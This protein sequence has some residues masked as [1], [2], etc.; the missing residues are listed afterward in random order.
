MENTL[1]VKYQ[2]KAL[3]IVVW[4]YSLSVVSAVGFVAF[5]RFIGI[6]TSNEIKW[7]SLLVFAVVIV[8]ELIALA[9]LYKQTS[10]PEKWK[11]YFKILNFLL[12]GICYVNYIFLNVLVPSREIW[13]IVFY[14]I[15]LAALFLDIKM[16]CSSIVLSVICNVILLKIDV[17]FMPDKQFVFREI[18]VRTI[19]I[20]FVSLGI[21]LFTY[22]ANG[23]LKKVDADEKLINEKNQKVSK[24]FDKISQFAE[25]ILSSSDSLAAAIEEENGGIQEI[26]SS[27]QY[28]SKSNSEILE[29]SNM[30]T[31]VLDEVLS[32]NKGV[33]FGTTELEKHSSYLVNLSNNNE[34]ALKNLLDIMELIDKGS[35]YNYD[36]ILKLEE[37]SNEVYNIVSNINNIAEQ[38]NLL[39]LNASIEAAR[40]GEAGKGFTVV[41]D[42]VR[43]LAEST[44]NSLEDITTIINQFKD[45]IGIVKKSISENNEKISSGRGITNTTVEDTINII[46]GLKQAGVNIN[47][48]N[49]SMTKLLNKTDNVVKFNADVADAVKDTIDKFETITEAI[50]QTAA[51]SEEIIASSEELKA[52]AAEM[53]EIKNTSND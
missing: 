1:V 22:L 31:K 2:K 9:F 26:A 4:L 51:T 50:N 11:T 27:S 3:K 35:G 32:I 10:K 8:I 17:F 29:R 41:A 33:S 19:V 25:V 12:I 24:L 15:V 16:V 37:K 23:I 18:I 40:A 5:L 21:L 44:R 7:S 43:K 28:V 38:T 45:E 53:N 47:N 6:Y 36:S 30:N 39:A 14:F 48:I 20:C 52:T 46:K 13:I 34:K 49:E 42:E